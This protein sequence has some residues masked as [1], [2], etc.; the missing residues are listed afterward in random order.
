MRINS[1][2]FLLYDNSTSSCV[3]PALRQVAVSRHNLRN[4][5]ER[6]SET[7]TGFCVFILSVQDSALPFL[8]IFFSVDRIWDGLYLCKGI[9]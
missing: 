7:Y 5:T 1:V 3:L 2:L 9:D 4:V 6:I 8:S